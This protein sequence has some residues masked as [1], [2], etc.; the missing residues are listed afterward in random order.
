MKELKVKKNKSSKKALKPQSNDKVTKTNDENIEPKECVDQAIPL[1]DVDLNELILEAE[2][3]DEESEKGNKILC[4]DYQVLD[5]RIVCTDKDDDFIPLSNF[6]AEIVEEIHHDDGNSVEI[7]YLIS[8]KTPERKFPN[9]EISA[10]KFSSLE[11][12]EANWGAHAI[13]EKGAKTHLPSAIKYLSKNIKTRTIYSHLGWREIDG[14]QYFLH[15]SGA[16]GLQE[17][18][19][20]IQVSTLPALSAYDFYTPT[21]IQLNDAF[22]AS[23]KI[24]ELCPD[25]ISYPL[26]AS[27]F[28]SPLNEFIKNDFTVFITGA[29]GSKKTELASIVLAHDGL[30]FNSRNLPANYTDTANALEKKAFFAKD[31]VLCVDDYC[32]YGSEPKRELNRKADRIIRGAGNQDGRARLNSNLVMQPEYYPRCLVISTGES[33]P[34]GQSMRAR[35]FVLRVDQKTVD[36]KTLTQMQTQGADGYFSTAKKEYI[37]WLIEKYEDF[38][39]NLLEKRK[40]Y[41]K[42]LNSIGIHDRTPDIIAALRIG[43]ETFLAFAKETK[44]LTEEQYKEHMRKGF[45]ALTAVAKKQKEYIKENEISS[46][47]LSWLQECFQENKVHVINKETG[48]FVNHTVKPTD[49][50]WKKENGEW[51]SQGELIGYMDDDNLYLIPKKAFE[52]VNKYALDQGA[53]FRTTERKLWHDMDGAG[54]LASTDP[55]RGSKTI[56]KVIL[57]K[58]RPFIHIMSDNIKVRNQ[59]LQYGEMEIHNEDGLN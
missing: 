51:K 1:E 14:D 56:R 49:W 30:K 31:C 57:N 20:E 22:K 44:M 17:P 37:R 26:L 40:E 59:T 13:I 39:M 3:P 23:M 12:V 33:L 35:T 48:G 50:G 52:V 16:I 27:I 34:E 8:G 43:L 2:T 4:H 6:T 32:V 58:R 55:S 9:A 54:I 41:R 21:E 11:W 25:E 29:T 5:E 28:L 24:L 19:H 53:P 7:T 36:I 42:E 46:V 15:A 47:F 18:K 45:D 10:I 38:K